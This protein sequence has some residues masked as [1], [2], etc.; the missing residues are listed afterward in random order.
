M[1]FPLSFNVPSEWKRH[2]YHGLGIA[3]IAC[4]GFFA[5]RKIDQK[6][7]MDPVNQKVV[8][9]ALPIVCGAVVGGAVKCA[10]TRTWDGAEAGLIVGAIS[11]G[12]GALLDDI[13]KIISSLGDLIPKTWS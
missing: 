11:G 1:N 10:R 2:L 5:K 4:G 8:S 13:K 9:Y 7:D 12:V 6:K 3:V